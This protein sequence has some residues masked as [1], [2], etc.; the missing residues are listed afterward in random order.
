[1]PTLV[2]RT[3][4]ELRSLV[5]EARGGRQPSLAEALSAYSTALE[6]RRLR[7]RIVR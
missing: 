3:Y 1:M 2:T 7:A 5:R 6:A 4:L